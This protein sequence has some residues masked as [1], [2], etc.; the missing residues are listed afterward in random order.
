M[1]V[2]AQR[3]FYEFVSDLKTGDIFTIYDALD[4]IRSRAPKHTPNGASVGH[5]AKIHPRV[6]RIENK[7]RRNITY[8]V[9]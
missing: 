8:G 5:M 3:I 1:D 7:T 9:L 2:V 4:Y 6:F